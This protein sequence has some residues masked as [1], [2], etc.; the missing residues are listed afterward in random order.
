MVRDRERTK[1]IVSL[2]LSDPRRFG[3]ITTSEGKEKNQTAQIKSGEN[4][5]QKDP[6]QITKSKE[7]SKEND[8]IADN[9]DEI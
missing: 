1:R 9:G 7:I 6:G 5:L 8:P 2:F 4:P 3:N